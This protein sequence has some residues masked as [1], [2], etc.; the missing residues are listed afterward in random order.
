MHP[1]MKMQ[2][3]M[4]GQIVPAGGP[5]LIEHCNTAQYLNC[6][7]RKYW[8]DFGEEFEVS[9]HATTR[10]HRAQVLMNMSE[11]APE[12]MSVKNQE[13]CN[14]WTISA[15][16]Q[17][18]RLPASQGKSFDMK[19]IMKKLLTQLSKMGCNGFSA[20]KKSFQDFDSDGSGKLNI[21]EFHKS[22]MFCAIALNI[23]EVQ[24]LMDFF[25]KDKSGSVEL[26]EFISALNEIDNIQ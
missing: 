23:T 7:E 20:L 18:L 12:S 26:E 17:V 4:V 1:D 13:K 15:G 3:K 5:V 2:A 6:E 14:I 9:A 25:D 21:E 11:G 22:L 10:F 24:K 16:T 8:N 19:R